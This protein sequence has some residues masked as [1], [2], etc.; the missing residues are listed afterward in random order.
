[1][2]DINKMIQW[3]SDRRGK[4]SYSMTDRLGPNNYD[5]SSAV[6]NALIAGGFLP[7]GTAIGNT[8]TL[9]NDLERNGWEQVQPDKNGNYPAK[10]GDVFIWGNRGYTLGAAGHTGIFID[11]QDNMIHCNAGYNSI[12]INDHD[13]I[14]SLNGFPAVTIYQYTGKNDNSTTQAS[15]PT[16]QPTKPT[17]TND[18][19][20]MRQY[21]KVIW[22]N[23][24]FKVDD[25]GHVN[26]MWQVISCELGGLPHTA[27][28]SAEEWTNNGVPMAG[29]S[30]TDGTPN[31]ST[32]GSRFKFDQDT[33]AIVDYDVASNGIAVMVAG[34][35]VWVD[36]TVAKRA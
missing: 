8:E 17:V 28:T 33:M 26:G 36:A 15:K 12:T 14:W 13:Y 9:F 11:D 1:M 16:P 34:F 30:W 32:Q 10:R 23:K 27:T 19:D 25:R 24:Q 4:V 31:S 7:Q 29:I 35:K 6:Y 18:V 22:N 2:P 20:Y 5:C 3:M 21:G